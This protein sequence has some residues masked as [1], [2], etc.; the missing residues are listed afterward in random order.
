MT[1][2]ENSFTSQR[3]SFLFY[4]HQTRI[5]FFFITKNLLI[6][7]VITNNN[8]KKKSY[9]LPEILLQLTLWVFWEMCAICT[10]KYFIGYCCWMSRLLI[11]MIGAINI[12]I[13][14]R[15]P[16]PVHE[17]SEIILLLFFYSVMNFIASFRNIIHDVYHCVGTCMYTYVTIMSTYDQCKIKSNCMLCWLTMTVC[18]LKQI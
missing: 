14:N 16:R 1:L 6:T 4:S 2:F 7:K 11:S 5:R 3:H 8:N 12:F 17:F 18:Y 10:F 9:K 15:A 13:N